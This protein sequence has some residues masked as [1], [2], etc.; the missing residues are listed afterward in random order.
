MNIPKTH[1]Y[2]LVTDIGKAATEY[3]KMCNIEICKEI[4]VTFTEE[5]DTIVGMKFLDALK[6]MTKENEWS[7]GYVH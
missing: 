4:F 1:E 5:L 7:Y 6:S 2:L 3:E